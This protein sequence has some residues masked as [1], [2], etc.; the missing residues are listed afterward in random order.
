MTRWLALLLVLCVLP[1]RAEVVWRYDAQYQ[2]G[3]L[4]AQ[5]TFAPGSNRELSV[6]DGCEPYVRDVQVL[7]NGHW[8]ALHEQEGSWFLGPHDSRVR[9]RFLLQ[10]AAQKLQ[11]TDLLASFGDVLLA[12]PGAFLLR[13]YRDDKGM[14][15]LQVSGGFVS[16][17]PRIDGS[18]QLP[19]AQV[20]FGP[21][22][23]FGP[24]H[25]VPI[26]VTGATLDVAFVPGSLP[27]QDAEIV[28]WVQRKANAVAN[29]YRHFPVKHAL[30]LILATAG[31]DIEGKTM[32]SGGASITLMVGRNQSVEEIERSWTITHEMVHTAFPSVRRNHHWI[33]EGLATYLE[34]IVRVRVGELTPQKVWHDLVAGLPQ[35]EPKRGDRGLDNTH[36]WGRTYW[37]GCLFCLLAD[38]QIR[39]QTHN[40]KGLGDAMRGILAAGGNISDDWP[41]QRCLKVGDEAVGLHVLEDLY[42]QMKDHP[43][44]IDLDA[45]WNQLGVTATGFSQGPLTNVRDAITRVDSKGSAAR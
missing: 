35:G 1:A 3:V 45:L 40:Q 33:E 23:A 39:E 41:L 44:P 16:G 11:D 10:P 13:P 34:P 38:V 9:Y 8:V 6:N 30:V 4:T 42:A 5:A 26:D 20:P 37:G 32:G 25:V 15:A 2:K 19:I 14:L 31:D 43:D 18:W 24:L 22:C 28:R 21:D 7:R 36:T 29:F 17:M 27:L 12:D